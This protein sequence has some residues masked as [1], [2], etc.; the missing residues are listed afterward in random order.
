MKMKI[1]YPARVAT[2]T[3]DE[4]EEILDL[5]ALDLFTRKAMEDPVGLTAVE[6]IL[7]AKQAMNSPA[8]Q[9]RR[10]VIAGSVT[11]DTLTRIKLRKSVQSPVFQDTPRSVFFNPDLATSAPVLQRTP[12]ET[13][14]LSGLSVSLQH[15][16]SDDAVNR[17]LT[18]IEKDAA[19]FKSR[20]DDASDITA[21]ANRLAHAIARKPEPVE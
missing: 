18:A 9:Q 4:D 19:K 2:L 3:L 17:R 10:F 13:S 14:A 6:L 1:D 8:L 20:R 12:A 15:H 7:D 5:P 11:S 16:Y 21:K